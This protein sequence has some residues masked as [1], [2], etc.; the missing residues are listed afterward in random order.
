MDLIASIEISS[1]IYHK[2]G[3]KSPALVP[4]PSAVVNVV[5]GSVPVPNA[6]EKAATP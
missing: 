5:A 3:T 4:F 1:F 2:T 6:G